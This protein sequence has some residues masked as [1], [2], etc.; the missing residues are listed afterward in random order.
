[1]KQ[2]GGDNYK[3]KSHQVLHGKLKKSIERMRLKP[4]SSVKKE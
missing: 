3:A 2:W 4:K 1:V